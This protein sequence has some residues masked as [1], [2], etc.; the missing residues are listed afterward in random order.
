MS[1]CGAALNTAQ[2]AVVDGL[3]VD[4]RLGVSSALLS[5]HLI[6]SFPGSFLEQIVSAIAV[7]GLNREPSSR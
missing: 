5:I 7:S 6:L 1:Y 3:A 4:K 2:H